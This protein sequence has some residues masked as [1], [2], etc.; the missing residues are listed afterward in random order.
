VRKT[1]GRKCLALAALLVTL[2]TPAVVV[3]AEPAI[4]APLSASSVI[5]LNGRAEVLAAQG[6]ATGS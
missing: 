2:V 3:A 4:A 5:G 1:M 6:T